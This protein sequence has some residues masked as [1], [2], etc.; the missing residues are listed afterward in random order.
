MRGLFA[1]G[2]SHVILGNIAHHGGHADQSVGHML[3]ENQ[4]VLIR[5]CAERMAE[6][7]VAATNAFYANLFSVAPGIR[8]LFPDDMFNQSEKLWNSIVMVVEGA[9]DM[10]EIRDAL[11]HL[12]ARHVH[13]GAE[14]EHYEVV[15]QVLIKTIAALMD[16][17]WTLAHQDA[18]QAALDAV[19]DIMLK[20]AARRET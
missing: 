1:F 10:G 4:I 15:T 17:Q 19:C 5:E 13:Y 12:G 3:T 2:A 20:G 16:N 18:W 8:N 7:N 14:P 6:T 9:D 11:E